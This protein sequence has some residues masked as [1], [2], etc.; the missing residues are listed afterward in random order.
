MNAQL[1][2]TQ[3]TAPS[4]LRPLDPRQDLSQVADLIQ[5]A[6][7][8][9]LEPGGLAALRDLRMLSR[10]GPLVG[11]MA[12]HDPYVE[13]VLGG[14]VWV[15]EGRVVGNVTIQRLD[16]YGSRWQIANVAVAQAFR[17]RGIGRALMTASLE[18]IAQ[19]HGHWAVLQVRADNA[20]ARGLYE[21]MGFEFVTQEVILRLQ[22]LEEGA[23]PVAM[24]EGMRP[25]DPEAWRACYELATA[26]RN[27]LDQWWYPVRSRDHWQSAESRLGQRIWELVGRNRVRR[28][29]VPG[30]HGLIAYL[31]LNARRWQG[32]HTLEFLVHPQGRGRLEMPLVHYAL[33]FLADYPRWPVVVQHKGQHPELIEALQVAGF[34]TRRNHVTMR[35]KIN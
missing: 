6:F 15:E 7:S 34:A 2:A 18:R 27:A 12:R 3:P 29:V 22:R 35:L 25:Y 30:E 20:V 11:L 17:G 1:V 28:W 9:E 4:G 33:G 16:S 8:G 13:D 14:F 23:T 21:Q 19:R 32:E 31:G 5:E 10:M 24:P 26:S